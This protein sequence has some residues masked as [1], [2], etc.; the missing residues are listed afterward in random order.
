MTLWWIAASRENIHVWLGKHKK[1]V[2]DGL[3]FVL[4]NADKGL[5]TKTSEDD[6]NPAN[7][8][9]KNG[10]STGFD[11][12]NE[13]GFEADSTHGHDNKEF[14]EFFERWKEAIADTERCEKSS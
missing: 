12:S 7:G 10:L 1:K 8:S 5:H 6:G 4:E 11:Q 9:E 2:A 13:I 14:R 3:P